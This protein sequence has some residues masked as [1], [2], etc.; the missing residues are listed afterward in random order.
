MVSSDS[1]LGMK[2][3]AAIIG[4]TVAL[5]LLRGFLLTDK[6]EITAVFH[7]TVLLARRNNVMYRGVKIGKVKEMRLAPGSDLVYVTMVVSPGLHFPP[8]AAA[9]IEP[10]SLMGSW[11]VQIISKGWHPELQFAKPPRAGLLPGAALPSLTALTAAATRLELDIDSLSRSFTPAKVAA[12]HR[13]VDQA[14]DL[15]NHLRGM[16]GV[17]GDTL[18]R[19]GG[20][21]LANSQKIL[22]LTQ[23]AR[24]TAQGM[25]D[26]L[27][28]GGSTVAMIASART[29]SANLAAFSAQLR[30]MGGRAGASIRGA[31][32]ML[33]SVQAMSESVG[34]STSGM[35]AS[36]AG[37]AAQLQNA[38]RGMRALE[39]MLSASQQDS[40][41]IGRLV[42]DPAAYQ[43]ALQAVTDLRKMLE[44]LQANP[45]KYIGPGK[46][47]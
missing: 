43:Q 32:S 40:S 27:T 1:K 29:A 2:A 45:G 19:T 9:L 15:S 17:Q 3:V 38:Q 4:I 20:G 18:S 41:A 13:T 31:D 22:A 14:E 30:R 8:D 23:G 37:A 5:V 36:A 46:T 47:R 44:D 35:G 10:Q 6:A 25:R 42:N 28:S 11:Q 21:I 12:I 26:T 34:R 16:V 7:E 39:Q 33:T 24:A